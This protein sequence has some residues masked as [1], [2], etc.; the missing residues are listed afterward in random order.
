MSQARFVPGDVVADR[1]RIVAL[2]GRGGMGEVY[3]ADDLTLGTRVALKFLPPE[4]AADEDYRERFLDEV[5]L[6]RQVS[7]PNICRVHDVGEA[8]AGKERLLFLSMEYVAGEDLASL[9]RRIG[10]LPQEKAN[11]MARQICMGVAAAHDQGILHRDL[12]P[13]NVLIDGDGRARVADFGLAAAAQVVRGAAARVGTPAYMAPEQLAG[14]EVSAASDVF[15]LGLVLFELYTGKPA[16]RAKTIEDLQRQHLE[17]DP[18]PSTVLDEIHPAADAIIKRCIARDPKERPRNAREV[19]L[20]LPGGDPLAAALAAGETPSL[21]LIAA[22]GHPGT[23]RP[24]VALALVAIIVGG[25]VFAALFERQMQVVELIQPELPVDVLTHRARELAQQF[26][27][28]VSR[29][30]SARGMSIAVPGELNLDAAADRWQRLRDPALGALRLWYRHSP[31]PLLPTGEDGRVRANDPPNDRRGMVQ[32]TLAQDGRLLGMRGM[33]PAVKAAPS[34]DFTPAL[35]A[36]R[37]QD[38]DLAE[39]PAEFVPTVPTT[40]TKSWRGKHAHSD[41][42]VR[43]DAAAFG[44]TLTWFQVAVTPRIANKITEQG[45]S[46]LPQRILEIS[47]AVFSL[48][49]LVGGIWLGARNLAQGRG[50]RRAATRIAVVLFT[51]ATVCWALRADHVADLGGFLRMLARQSGPAMWA[52]DWRGSCSWRSSPPRAASGPRRWWRGVGCSPVSS[53][54]PISAAPSWWAWPP[55][56][57]C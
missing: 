34:F 41:A 29:G 53:A 57:S 47:A 1:Y 55:P 5:R 12:K 45:A 33:P 14:K 21:E 2:L 28:D 20:A 31:A 10:R 38:S 4:L 27:Y 49:V 7:H 42:D 23:L 17:T 9:L 56:W 30:D 26:G 19:A 40:I 15:A 50:D 11:E 37:L 6:A 8:M 51:L 39:I 46:N 16:Y 24:M 43:V 3:R 32:I 36:A 13:G 22:S 48:V 35:A 25:V 44:A 52:G 54:T 18:T